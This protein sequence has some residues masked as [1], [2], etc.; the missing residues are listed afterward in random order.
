M[1][2]EIAYCMVVQSFLFNTPR[3]P[4]LH[5]LDIDV[6]RARRPYHMAWDLPWWNGKPYR[7]HRF[8]GKRAPIIGFT[9]CVDVTC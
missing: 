3:E 2:F 5:A 8:E 6:Q 7:W 4:V 1:T 9:A